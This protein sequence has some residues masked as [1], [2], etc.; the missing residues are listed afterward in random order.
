MLKKEYNETA[1][2]PRFILVLLIMQF[3]IVNTAKNFNDYYDISLI[4]LIV[5]AVLFS[6]KLKLKISSDGV[7]Y[8]LIPFLNRK[9]N[10]QEIQSIK[11]INVSAI[12]DFM[13]WGIRY[14]NKFGWGYIMHSGDAVVIKKKNG[15]K[16]TFS[17]KN[18]LELE[19]VLKSINIS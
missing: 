2:L 9:I 17:V 15:K 16:V 1:R 10:A 7:K 19:K 6:V 4:V 5:G 18:P 8:S 11:L 3:I 13:G 14:S 12:E